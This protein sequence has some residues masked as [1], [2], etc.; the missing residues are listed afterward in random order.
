MTRPAPKIAIAQPRMFWTSS[1]NIAES[2]SIATNAAEL[3]A[4]ICVFPELSVT[5]Y[6][7]RIRDEAI[8]AIVEPSLQRM[9]LC[10]RQLQMTLAVGLPTFCSN[11][12]IR[13]AYMFIDSQGEELATV[14]KRGL[15]EP[16]ATFFVQGSARPVVRLTGLN[17]SAFIC[18]EIEDIDMVCEDF[19]A[20]RPNVLL[21]PGLMGPEEGA[22]HLSPPRHVQHARELARRTNSY[23][24]QSN[25]PMSLN[26]P[27]LSAKAGRSVVIGPDGCIQAY[28]PQARAGFAVFSLGSREYAWHGSEV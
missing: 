17:Y 25:W 7:R 21:W 3:G 27:D 22:E 24:V 20:E 9:K 10:A 5:G 28:L 23:I 11:G 15:T 6:H 1:E 13:N 2:I 18:R 19:A 8:P 14:E 4:Q 26:Y 16:E 12:G